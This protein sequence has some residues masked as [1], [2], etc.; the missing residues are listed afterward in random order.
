L[1]EFG[2]GGNRTGLSSLIPRWD[3]GANGVS[4]LSGVLGHFSS[5]STSS[6]LSVV[7]GMVRV[8]MRKVTRV[9]WV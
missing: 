4:A 5:G 1:S 6:P 2:S 3:T 9:L 7:A 8:G